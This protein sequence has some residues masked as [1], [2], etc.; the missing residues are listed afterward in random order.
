MTSS[1]IKSN[2]ELFEYIFKNEIIEYS[3]YK[4]WHSADEINLNWKNLETQKTVLK[5]KK[6]NGYINDI[7][8]CAISF[9]DDT[10][11]VYGLKTTIKNNDFGFL[12]WSGYT[13][14]MIDEM[15]PEGLV[16]SYT[17]YSNDF[18]EKLRSYPMFKLINKNN[19]SNFINFKIGEGEI[20]YFKL[21]KKKKNN[22]IDT[23]QSDIGEEIEALI[24][25]LFYDHIDSEEDFNIVNNRIKFSD[26]SV[27]FY[28]E[29]QTILDDDKFV[30]FSSIQDEL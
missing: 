5:N 11:G 17:F 2:Y 27:T 23:D 25:D 13:T 21:L 18:I 15:E 20:F 6:L 14:D 1:L 10:G 29:E 9:A 16:N 26:K 28:T 22:W 3:I 8:N 24:F 30:S 19:L 7:L 4:T 12:I